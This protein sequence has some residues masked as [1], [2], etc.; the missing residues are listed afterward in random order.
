MA[1]SSCNTGAP[2]LQICL[3]QIGS[4]RVSA[5]RWSYGRWHLRLSHGAS[6]FCAFPAIRPLALG[7]NWRT[8]RGPKGKWA[9]QIVQAGTSVSKNE[10]DDRTD[11]LFRCMVC[12]NMAGG[13]V[14]QI[15]ATVR[16]GET[17]KQQVRSVLQ[18]RQ[19]SQVTV[20]VEMSD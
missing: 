7:S 18:M 15:C 12:W 10:T 4:K 14:C 13:C 19:A 17:E 16:C 8:D 5:P 2:S 1:A 9:S 20:Y 11:H 6:I 3:S